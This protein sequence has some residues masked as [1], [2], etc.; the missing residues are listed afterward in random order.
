MISIFRKIRQKLL[1]QNRFSRYLVYAIGEIFLVMIGIL[2]ALQINNWNENR[3]AKI[4]EQT[5]LKT[6]LKDIKESF[7]S[8][9]RYY[10]KDSI[11]L[12]YLDDFLAS[13]QKR[14][15]LLLLPDGEKFIMIGIWSVETRTPV[16]QVFEDLKNSGTSSEI[17]NQEIRKKLSLI[18]AEIEQIKFQIEDKMYIQ[19]TYLDPFVLNDLDYNGYALYESGESKTFKTNTVYNSFFQNKE[20]QNK[21]RAKARLGE[22]T[23]EMRNDL[24]N[25]MKDL[26]SEIELEIRHQ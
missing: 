15:S 26:I 12:R 24:Q 10:K 13:D 5:L 3:K 16:I 23:L 11:Q 22:R 19:R 7:E 8:G 21:L 9:L 20:I 6:L 18:N 25:Q 14:D 1:T 2:M 17:T 4:K